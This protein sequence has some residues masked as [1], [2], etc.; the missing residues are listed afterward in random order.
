VIYLVRAVSAHKTLA[1]GVTTTATVTSAGVNG[2]VNYVPHWKL[3]LKFTDNQ[4]K[5]RWFHI[6]RTGAGYAEGD[7]FQIKY[8]PKRPGSTRS[9]VV[10]DG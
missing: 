1:D 10:M 6:G 2:M 7:T 5:D 4:G 8:D 9:I 3:T